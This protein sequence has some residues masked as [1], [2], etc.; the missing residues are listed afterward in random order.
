MTYKAIVCKL[1]NVRE[2][3]KLHSLNV[4]TVQGHQILVG[5]DAVEGTLGIFYPS[6]GC[7]SDEHLMSNNSYRKV[8]KVIEPGKSNCKSGDIMSRRALNSLKLSQ[9]VEFEEIDG[10]GYFEPSGRVKVMK[11]QG[12]PSDG[13]WHPIE[14]YFSW[15][16]EKY[17]KGLEVGEEIDKIGGNMLCEKYMTPA[18][19]KAL[20][21]QN[22]NKAKKKESDRGQNLQQHYDTGH[23]E[24]IWT[25]IEEGSILTFTE[26]LHG[27]SG[28]TG[29]V[30]E[31]KEHGILSMFQQPK[32]VYVTG[33]RRVI[34]VVTDKFTQL[35]L[36]L[37]KLAWNYTFGLFL[38]KFKAKSSYN[39]NGYYK[40]TT[41]R[42]DIHNRIK[43]LGLRKGECVYYEI[44][45]Y[46]DT[47][48]S[49]MPGHTITDSKLKKKFGNMMLYT[50]GCNEGE[51]KIF[52]YRIT[53]LNDENYTTELD[54]NAVKRRCNELGLEHVPDLGTVIYNGDD[55]K[56][57]EKCI[58][59]CSGRSTLDDKHIMEGICVRINNSFDDRSWKYKSWHFRNLEGIRK[60]D[61][62][63][64]DPEEIA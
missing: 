6:D 32:N 60:D 15:V 47:G 50:Y 13:Y 54:W 51:Y 28:R 56:L 16:S 44:V 21:G 43:L 26:K 31:F 23:I 30:K 3:D 17:V 22:N 42:V 39:D 34:S 27:T 1:A 10:G 29:Y 25:D 37:H 40:G 64:V 11:F 4:A 46:T 7:I 57:K 8:I 35:D 62:A 2:H 53:M 41:F 24:K 9:T 45:G 63:Y 48:A 49:I 14:G 36:P 12:I 33:T 19:R 52:V 59:V 18:T 55:E 20:R 5:K 61:D 58:D 38:K